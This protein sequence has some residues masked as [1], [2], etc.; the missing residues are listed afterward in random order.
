MTEEKTA[1]QVYLDTLL[2]Y[3][4]EEIIGEGY[5]LG[6]AKRFPD[7]DQR[8]KMTYLAKVERCAANR[9]RPLLHKYGLKPRLDAE[10]FKC[11]K[12]DIEHSFSL[13]WKGLIDHMVESYPNYMPEFRALEAMAPNEDIACLKR[14]TA[15][16][17]AAIEFATLEQAGGQNS[18]TPLQ[19]YI[20]SE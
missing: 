6:L 10:L 2:L 11:A 13:G 14:L 9:V 7:Q 5:F 3:F 20:A 1:T 8:E 16:E 12:E 18:L 15:H 17:V 4:E 19:V